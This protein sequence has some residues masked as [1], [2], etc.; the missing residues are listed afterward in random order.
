M[1]INTLNE[2]DFH[3]KIKKIY[4]LENNGTTEVAAEGYIAD[5]LCPKKEIIEIQTGSFSHLKAKIKTFL[6]KKYKVTVVFPFA[7]V[8]II[9]TKDNNS[10]IISRRKS[11][12][13]K[14]YYTCFREL[15]SIQEYILHKN[16][17]I[18]LLPCTITEE[19][20]QTE[21]LVQSVNKKRRFLK[22]Y[23]KTGK[24]LED[25]GK[26]LILKNKKD[27]L[28]LLLNFSSKDFTIK[29]FSLYLKENGFSVTDRYL[30]NFIWLLEKKEII[31][32]KDKKGRQILYSPC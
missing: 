4:A 17:T 23:L 10:K 21:E 19:R 27:Y 5:I 20:L 2:S 14:N 25:T 13:K 11:P 24:R 31:Y 7:A 15:T 22:N 9:E 29:E 1:M 8:K 18:H 6:D 16:L 32:R 30:R 26:R 12:L 28:K 3:K